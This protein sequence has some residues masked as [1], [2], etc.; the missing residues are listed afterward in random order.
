MG[1]GVGVSEAADA[2]AAAS[3][4]VRRAFGGRVPNEHDL[5]VMFAGAEYDVGALYAAGVQ[6]AA[7]ARVV[8]CTATGSFTHEVQ[9]TRGCVAAVLRGD[10]RR[11]GVCHVAREAGDIAGSARR[12]S[13]GARERAGEGY[14]HSLLILLTDGMTPDQRE[15]ARGAYEITGA[16]VPFVGGAAADSLSWSRTLTFGDGVVR[17]DGI[18]A[19]WVNSADA[20]AVSVGHGWR[21]AGKPMLVTRTGGTVVH[22]LDGV[23]AVDAYLADL[24]IELRADDPEFFLK[25]LENP[26]GIPNSRGRYDVRQLHAY[27]PEGGGLNFNTGISE[28]SIVQVMNSDS[29]SLLDGAR[30]AAVTAARQLERPAQMALAFSCGSRMPL[31]GDRLAEE[32]AA[33]SAALGGAAV[34]G[35]YTYGEFARVNGSSGVHNSS[36]AILAL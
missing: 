22:E 28:H 6:A 10:G 27:L 3:Q 2:A 23:A 15:V 16:L 1:S 4:A 30:Q 8:G 34:C 13:S 36:V 35:F 12:A 19:V 31:L 20:L 21:P 33:I 26:V 5:V 7:P 25:V 29:D 18:L 32:A 11:Y 17:E 9:V 14:A 24:S